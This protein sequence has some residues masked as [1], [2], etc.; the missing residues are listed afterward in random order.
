MQAFQN[1]VMNNMFDQWKSFDKMGFFK[2]WTDSLKSFQGNNCFSSFHHKANENEATMKS[3]K[4]INDM[5]SSGMR[6]IEAISEA[7]QKLIANNQEAVKKKADVYQ[8]SYADVMSLFKELLATRNPE[9]AVAKQTDFFKKA[10]D[11]IV[12]DFKKLTESVATSNSKV[13]ETLS[14]KLSANIEKQTK[15]FKTAAANATKGSK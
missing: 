13:F 2:A 11:N 1:N 12:T 6:N 3:F 15:E 10:F 7:S 8:R 14:A 9:I 5:F 4:A